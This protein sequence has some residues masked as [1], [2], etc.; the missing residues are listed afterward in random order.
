MSRSHT[1]FACLANQSSYSGEVSFVYFST[2]ET[3]ALF[4]AKKVRRGEQRGSMAGGTGD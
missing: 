2:F 1:V 3:N 4:Y